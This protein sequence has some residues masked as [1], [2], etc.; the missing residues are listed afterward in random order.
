MYISLNVIV[1]FIVIF[2]LS[3]C[4]KRLCAESMLRSLP[5]SQFDVPGPRDVC[6]PSEEGRENFAVEYSILDYGRYFVRCDTPVPDS[7]SVRV[8]NLEDDEYR[9]EGL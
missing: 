5:V 7:S 3:L 1:K 8:I 6:A 2:V 4:T 9:R